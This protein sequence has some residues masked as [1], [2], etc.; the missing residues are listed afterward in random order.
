MDNSKNIN[1]NFFSKIKIIFKKYWEILIIIFIAF[2]F[3][4]FSSSYNFYFQKNNFVKWNSPDETANYNF[5]KLYA[6]NKELSF[7]EDDNIIGGDII[8]PR[9]FRSD[10]GVMKPM[11][12][13]GL[14][15]VYGSISSW[16]CFD[17]IPFLTPFFASVGILF[18]YLFLRNI[19]GR[20][21][22][23][24]SSIILASFPVYFYYTARSMF[25][26]VL[27]IVF[28]LIS[29]LCII[30]L[31]K[32]IFQKNKYIF[33]INIFLIF[34][35]GY[36]LGLAI[37]T[38]TSEL[39]WII[40][41]YVILGIFNL[42]NIGLKIFIFFISIFLA[43]LPVFKWNYVLYSS[44]YKGGYPEMNDS[45]VNITQASGE[46]VK[47]VVNNSKV[48]FLKEKAEVI[49]E[50]IFHFG[51][52][53]RK[54]LKMFYYYFIDMFYYIFWPTVFGLILFFNEVSRWKKKYWLYLFSL[55]F[56]SLILIFY[57]GSWEFHDNPDF[58]KHTIGN[59]YTR[60]WL[61]IYLGF[62]PFFSFFIIQ[63]TSG[64]VNLIYLKIKNLRNNFYK[65]FKKN[66]KFFLYFISK[67][68]FVFHC[69]KIF[70]IWGLRI[71]IIFVVTLLSIDFILFGSDEGLVYAFNK[72]DLLF[73]EYQKVL[74]ITEKN[75]II[76]TQ[77]HDKLFFPERKVI[78]GKF[79]NNEI[80]NIYR[81]LIS[82]KIP[83]YYYSFSLP[84]KDYEYLNKRKLKEFNLQIKFVEK[85]NINFSLYELIKL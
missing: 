6:Q 54:S 55:L 43:L 57:Y 10:Y 79:D 84:K 4:I 7:I 51:F 12:F 59:S 40:P 78:L 37:I 81:K 18:Y 75:S 46:L 48:N 19:F 82:E 49:K 72:R 45:I 14:M 35:S 39:I 42:R 58:S 83:L 13:L 3:F 44:F 30:F 53:P 27:F 36:F 76:I 24:L 20:S 64:F 25:H 11:S 77:Y 16:F 73:H 34:L 69:R 80:N 8:R 47:S 41:L 28:L 38:R 56:I 23:F 52:S 5:T 21:N 26:N 65:F 85:I 32:I 71:L 31:K 15:L 29:L 17:I 63:F 61:P 67:C 70:I 22:A 74:D 9:S 60:Y 50:N 1:I 66:K 62:L 68:S 33:L 2:L